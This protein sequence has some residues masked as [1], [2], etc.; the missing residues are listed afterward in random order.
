MSAVRSMSWKGGGLSTLPKLAGRALFVLLALIAM[1]SMSKRRRVMPSLIF[2]YII[3]INFQRS[4]YLLQFKSYLTEHQP[5]I[6]DFNGLFTPFMFYME[7]NLLKFDN[8]N[9]EKFID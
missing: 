2:M 3:T 7:D 5:A 6:F 8:L 9:D 4:A 1:A